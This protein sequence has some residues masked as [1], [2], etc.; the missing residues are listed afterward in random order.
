MDLKLNDNKAQEI[1]RYYKKIAAWGRNQDDYDENQVSYAD[2]LAR[3]YEKQH[4][5]V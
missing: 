4:G 2:L 5:T 3:L 1:F